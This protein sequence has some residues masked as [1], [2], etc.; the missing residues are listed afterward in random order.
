MW[1][2]A[3]SKFLFFHLGTAL[4]AFPDQ[5]SVC[6]WLWLASLCFTFSSICFFLPT[7][8]W[9]NSASAARIRCLIR[10]PIRT[11]KC[12]EGTKAERADLEEQI[13][14]RWW[15]VEEMTREREWR[16][17]RRR[18][19]KN[20]YSQRL[21]NLIKKHYVFQIEYSFNPQLHLYMKEGAENGANK[22]QEITEAL[23]FRLHFYNQIFSACHSPSSPCSSPRLSHPFL[24]ILFF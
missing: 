9:D 21:Q 18:T 17:W 14:R 8:L 24:S 22:C 19:T 1:L 12:K 7:N 3:L 15:W 2:G 20:I 16:V 13:V 23:C 5:W 6:C 4:L 10:T 11:S